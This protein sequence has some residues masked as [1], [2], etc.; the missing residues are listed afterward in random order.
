MT[1]HNTG[2][3]ISNHLSTQMLVFHLLSRAD[4]QVLIVEYNFE[5][6]E[7]HLTTYLFGEVYFDSTA[8]Q[9]KANIYI[10]LFPLK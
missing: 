9:A 2:S 5:M 8:L 1:I 6:L 7:L 4:F 10:F 3:F